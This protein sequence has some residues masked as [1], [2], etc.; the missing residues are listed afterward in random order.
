MRIWID[1]DRLV[2][3]KIAPTEVIQAIQQENVQAAA[4]KIGGRPVPA[5]QDFELPTRV[6]GR[7]EK[8]SEFEEIIVRRGDDGSIVRLKDVARVELVVGELRVGPL[9]R[10]QAGRRHPELPVRRRQRAG[11]HPH[12]REE[13]DQL[14]ATSRKGSTTRS[15]TT[16][17]TSWTRTA[18]RSRTLVE[19][20]VLVMIVVFVFL[21]SLRATII[22]TLVDPGLAGRHVRGDGGVRLLDQRADDVRAGAGDR[23]GGRRRDHRGRERREDPHRE[24]LAP[25]EATRAAMGRDHRALIGITAGAGRR[26]RPGGVHAGGRQDLQPVRDDDRLLDPVLGVHLAL[27]HPG[28]VRGL[29]AGEAG[30][31]PKVRPVPLVQPRL[32]ARP[33]HGYEAASPRSCAA[34]GDSWCSS[35]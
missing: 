10:R 18:R 12:V 2:D 21:Q 33:T 8:A 1:P 22:P 11:D 9:H 23:P 20:F 6:K 29:P 27:V 15:C 25:R 16:R 14:K 28:D 34:P 5:G 3:M 31:D 17:P 35:A 32:Q 26:V 7:L 4:G 13:M 24:G 19:S 30:R